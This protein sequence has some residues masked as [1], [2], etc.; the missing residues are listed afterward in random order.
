[1]R[2]N[3]GLTGSVSGCH[4]LLAS[5]V[6]EAMAAVS[7]KVLPSAVLDEQIRDEV[8]AFYGDEYDACLVNTCE[9]GLAVSY[10][11]LCQAPS[12][13]RGDTYRT[14]YMAPYERHMHHQG[15]YGRPSPQ[16]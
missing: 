4:G 11:V 9:A 3:L 7:R 5:E 2:G 15:A 12:M 13:G 6:E 14:R 1:M 10:E 8:K 16:V